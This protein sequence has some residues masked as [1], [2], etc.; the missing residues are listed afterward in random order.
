MARI[1]IRN[2]LF[3]PTAKFSSLTIPWCTYTAPEVAHVGLYESDL[4]E[5][6]IKYLTFS[7]N[8]KNVDRFVRF[9]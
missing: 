9:S 6:G 8:F 2:A 4:K 3:Y 5:R 7:R 1:V